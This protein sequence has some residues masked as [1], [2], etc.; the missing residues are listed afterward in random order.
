MTT[1]SHHCTP[2]MMLPSRFTGDSDDVFF[3]QWTTTLRTAATGVG[4]GDTWDFVLTKPNNKRACRAVSAS[5]SLSPAASCLFV[6]DFPFFDV[7]LRICITTFDFVLK[8]V[9]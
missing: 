4:N 7:V 2:P 3:N 8:F 5:G 9:S 6:F 1:H